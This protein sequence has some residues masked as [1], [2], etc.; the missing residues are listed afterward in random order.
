MLIVK[1]HLYSACIFLKCVNK[2]GLGAAP[3]NSGLSGRS[4]NGLRWGRCCAQFKDEITEGREVR[5]FAQE[6]LSD[7]RSGTR[8]PTFRTC[9]LLLLLLFCF[10]FLFFT[11][12]YNVTVLFTQYL[13]NF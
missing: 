10:L 6:R 5:Y 1:T 12:H 4:D 11:P 3:S 8:F 7:K 2:Q 13:N 9:F